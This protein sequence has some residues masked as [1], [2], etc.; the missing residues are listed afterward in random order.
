MEEI[1]KCSESIAHVLVLQLPAGQGTLMLCTKSSVTWQR[2]GRTQ[3]RYGESRAPSSG[4]D[5]EFQAQLTLLQLCCLFLFP[6][7]VPNSLRGCF[8]PGLLL[9]L[10]TQHSIAAA[11]PRR[12]RRGVGFV[13]PQAPLC[14]LERSTRLKKGR[15]KQSFLRVPWEDTGGSQLLFASRPS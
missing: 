10:G 11:R 1:F 7:K 6:W 2:Y 4:G 15:V 8:W 12:C 9:A 14:L 3:Q 13:G 5:R